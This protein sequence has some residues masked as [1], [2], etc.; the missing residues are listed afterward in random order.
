VRDL[1]RQF[2]ILPATYADFG[3][4]VSEIATRDEK[5]GLVYLRMN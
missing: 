3:R 1:V 2:D 4:L 5:T